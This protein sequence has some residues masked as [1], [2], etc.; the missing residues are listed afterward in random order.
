MRKPTFCICENKDVDQLRGNH[1]EADQR[2]CFATRI[3]QSLFFLNPKF[4]ASSNLLWLYSPASV[5]PGRKPRRPF[6]SERG[7]YVMGMFVKVHSV[8]LGYYKVYL[9]ITHPFASE[10]LQKL[11]YQLI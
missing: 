4:Q 6:F 7:S 3:V 9:G 2:L 10:V 11:Q 5:G 1:R 8:Y